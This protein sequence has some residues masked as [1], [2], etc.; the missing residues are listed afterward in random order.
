MGALAIIALMCFAHEHVLFGVVTQCYGGRKVPIQFAISDAETGLPVPG[1][2]L[3]LWGRI[4]RHHTFNSG[5]DGRA[6]LIFQPGC[7]ERIYLLWG[8]YY[9]V[10]YSNWE[11]EIA[12]EGYEHIKCPLTDYR[13]D[14]RY[15]GKAVPPP[16]EVRLRRDSTNL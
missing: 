6:N 9:M 14:T 3:E 7:D 12:A 11:L 15:P 4:D 2:R 10:Y 16:I 5:S 8:S 13:A 1:A